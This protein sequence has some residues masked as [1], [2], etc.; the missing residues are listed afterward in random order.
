[1][2]TT[3]IVHQ[4]NLNKWTDIIREQQSS[5]LTVKDWCSQ[6]QVSKDQFYYWKRKLKDTFVESPLPDIIPISSGVSEPCC[7]SCTT[8]ATVPTLSYVTIS[9][10][11]ISIEIT[12]NTSE[13]LLTKV[14]KAVRNA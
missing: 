5:S 6:H 9:I 1:M 8:D 4:T 2:N 13:L 7:T 3:Q 14:I 10:N 12:D 11:D